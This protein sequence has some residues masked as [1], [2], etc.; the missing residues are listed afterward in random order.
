MN[1]HPFVLKKVDLEKQYFLMVYVVYSKS[2]AVLKSILET[3]EGK[4]QLY[5]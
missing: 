2:L 4:L 1:S 3:A 5:F